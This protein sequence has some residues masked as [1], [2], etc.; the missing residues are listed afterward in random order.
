MHSASPHR[1]LRFIP[2]VEPVEQRLPL[3]DA[4]LGLW[5]LGIGFDSAAIDSKSITLADLK[6]ETWV[7]GAESAAADE[8]PAERPDLCSSDRGF[9]DSAPATVALEY[10]ANRPESVVTWSQTAANVS[11]NRPA[12]A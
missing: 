4:L 9:E 8:G 7:V 1:R 11:P 2:R 6:S 5:A 12:V 3:G 10:V